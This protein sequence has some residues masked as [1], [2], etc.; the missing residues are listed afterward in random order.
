MLYKNHVWHGEYLNQKKNPLLNV[1]R[2][3][4][5]PLNNNNF[6]KNKNSELQY[7]HLNR[8]LDKYFNREN[9]INI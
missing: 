5:A 9:S 2:I 7:K 3:R 4:K 8:N 6:K 1:S